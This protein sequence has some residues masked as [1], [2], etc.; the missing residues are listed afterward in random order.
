MVTKKV[1][2]GFSFIE[3]GLQLEKIFITCMRDNSVVDID[4]TPFLGEEVG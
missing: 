2:E 3:S 1:H 4:G